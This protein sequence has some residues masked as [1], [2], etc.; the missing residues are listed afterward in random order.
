[1]RARLL[2]IDAR[3]RSALG[4]LKTRLGLSDDARVRPWSQMHTRGTPGA[5]K[6]ADNDMEKVKLWSARIKT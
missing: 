5:R 3:L 6:P 2:S 4:G 1:M